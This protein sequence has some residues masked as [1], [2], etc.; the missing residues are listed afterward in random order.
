VI[1]VLP[2]SLTITPRHLLSWSDGHCMNARLYTA[3]LALW[4]VHSARLAYLG[5]GKAV[6]WGAIRTNWLLAC[7]QL[8]KV[9]TLNKGCERQTA[10]EMW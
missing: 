2:E 9:L 5:G 4:T 10:V 7:R 6:S 3:R 8:Y 1:K